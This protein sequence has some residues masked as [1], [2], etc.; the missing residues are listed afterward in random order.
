MAAVKTFIASFRR[1]SAEAQTDINMVDEIPVQAWQGPGAFQA[2]T[3]ALRLA[4]DAA[5][6]PPA[7]LHG[8]PQTD[9]DMAYVI[10][11]VLYSYQ[12]HGAVVVEPARMAI[13]L[14]RIAAGWKI[15]GWA[16]AGGNPQA[17]EQAAVSRFLPAG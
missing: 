5:G 15:T 4:S 9:R 3:N 2:W 14:R 13:S 1:E 11:P 16:W 17:S 7:T 6:G 8:S 12:T 10:A